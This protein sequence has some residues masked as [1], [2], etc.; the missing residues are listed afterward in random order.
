M[1]LSN[2]IFLFLFCFFLFPNFSFKVLAQ[3]E[4]ST[5][6]ETNFIILSSGDA[7]VSQQISLK[8]L[9]SKTFISSYSI[10]I[11]GKKPSNIKVSDQN[12]DNLPFEVKEDF[13]T[14]IIL[15]NFQ[16]SLVGKNKERVFTIS[17]NLSNVAVKNG[18]VWDISIPKIKKIEVVQEYNL[19]VLVPVSFGDL[20]YI[21][22]DTNS[23]IVLNSFYTF[24]FSKADLLKSGIVAAFGKF[25]TFSFNLTYH[26][27]NPN[28]KKG[29]LE[30]ALVPDTAYQ[31]VYYKEIVPNPRAIRLDDDGNWLA[32]YRLNEN[33][34]IEVK[35]S[36][37]TQIFAHPQENYPK[38]SPL[39]YPYLLSQTQYWQTT[40]AEIAKI[41]ALLK[42]PR[43]IYDF[44]VNKLEYDYS[45]IKENL[46][47]FG[48]K[49]ALA[50]PAKA[51]CME[52][53]DLFIAIT[54]AAGIPAR[55]ING[56]A[57][58]ENPKLQ[59]LSLVTDVLH[60]WPEYW[61]S[62]K[63]EW[64][65]VDP[66]WEDTTG[67][68]D[69]FDK[70]DLAHV[71]FVIHGKE[72]NFPYP[73][74]SYKSL[75]NTQQKDVLVEFGGIPE[76]TNTQLK[77]SF[78]SNG[79]DL[80]FKTLKRKALIYNSGPTA[81]YNLQLSISSSALKTWKEQDE[82]AFLAPFSSQEIEFKFDLPVF[83]DF[84][85]KY[86]VLTISDEMIKYDIPEIKF[87]L[88]EGTTILAL[89]LAIS[90]VIF[91]ILHFTKVKN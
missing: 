63:N 82:I 11:E 36:L 60:S 89:F 42:T 6:N 5:S 34:E 48:S 29:D 87:Y 69:Y 79:I 71:T 46:P 33:Q 80:P 73:A 27:K 7:Q 1:L 57:Y 58:T 66:T 40:D 14:T 19:T 64:K 31:K 70:F 26:L 86:A 8:N 35:A 62:S 44:V 88:I 16:D 53:T 52:F 56:Y 15:I 76:T 54:R 32:S 85:Q 67:G 13:S 90:G 17:Y 38:V 22:P 65:P 68:I 91:L 9:E 41:A 21:S 43:Q 20:A 47:R 37:I 30:I 25:Q 4:Y 10:I 55:E 74:G 50:N 61:D 28:S 2:L 39:K 18:D 45:R 75:N 59:P 3:E 24:S 78:T 81:L 84:K 51:I 83:P 77:V 23:K 72:S 49:D 12:K